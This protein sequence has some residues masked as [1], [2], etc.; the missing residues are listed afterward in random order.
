M[1]LHLYIVDAGMSEPSTTLLYIYLYLLYIFMRETG[2]K[3]QKL[4]NVKRNVNYFLSFILYIICSKKCDKKT[5]LGTKRS[6]RF[7]SYN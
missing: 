6:V 4:V 1:I 2:L 7:I 3:I 5:I